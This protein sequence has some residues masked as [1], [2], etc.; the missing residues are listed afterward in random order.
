MRHFVW[1]WVEGRDGT[2]R[3]Q[4][5]RKSGRHAR[6]TLKMTTEFSPPPPFP[7]YSTPEAEKGG[8]IFGFSN[9][10]RKRRW[11]TWQRPCFQRDPLVRV[12]ASLCRVVPFP[13]PPQGNRKVVLAIIALGIV[14]LTSVSS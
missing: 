7:F 9:L 4:V 11:V 12:G 14:F 8:L 6:C 3:T 13:F 5:E 1:G 10:L 2:G